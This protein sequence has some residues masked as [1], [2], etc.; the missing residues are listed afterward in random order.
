MGDTAG[1]AGRPASAGPSTGTGEALGRAASDARATA[2]EARAQ[3]G[4]AASR[5]RDEAA[6]AYADVKAEAAGVVDAARERAEGFAEQQKHAGADRAEG[7]ARAVHR[8]AEELQGTSPQLAQYVRQ[9]AA[10]VHH[11][12]RDMRGRSVG[13]LLGDV[14]GMARRQPLAFFGAAALAGFALSRFLKSSAPGAHGATHG[15]THQAVYTGG[16]HTASGGG[17]A[18]LPAPGAGGTAASGTVTGGT[19][20]SGTVTGGTAA[21]GTGTSGMG[22]SGTNRVRVLSEG[23]GEHGG[24]AGSTS[25]VGSSTPPLVG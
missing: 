13:D 24:A 20:A 22:A 17:T 16:G 15:A 19:A 21:G 1:N 5:V 14:E 8:A 2:S 3:A 10:S 7:L 25:G 11:L 12:S 23:P 18:A 9:A 6:G 4:E